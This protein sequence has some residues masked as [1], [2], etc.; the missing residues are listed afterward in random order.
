MAE[1]ELTIEDGL[2][3]IAASL[4][5]VAHAIH[6]LGNADAMTPFGGMEALGMAITE[7]A[8]RIASALTDEI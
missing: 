4:D 3:A 5:R 8:D 2:F 6:R 7:A 1:N